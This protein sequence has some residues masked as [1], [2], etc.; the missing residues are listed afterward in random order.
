VVDI[1][2]VTVND[3]VELRTFGLKDFERTYRFQG[4]THPD[5][6][7]F[8]RYLFEM[9]GERAM[10]DIRRMYWEKWS[11]LEELKAEGADSGERRELEDF[12]G[13]HVPGCN[14][15]VDKGWLAA[16]DHFAECVL[17]GERPILADATAA[18]K[19]AQITQAAIQSR[20]TGEVV[21]M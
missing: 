10:M 20:T 16:V 8:H 15:M 14:Y 17:S 6:D 11:R 7:N 13:K 18:M 9:E 5:R 12:M 4:H 3:F 21:K 1:G 19:A 2:A